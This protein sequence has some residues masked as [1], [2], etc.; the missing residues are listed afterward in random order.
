[1]SSPSDDTLANP[2]PPPSASRRTRNAPSSPHDDATIEAFADEMPG[3]STVDGSFAESNGDGGATIVESGERPFRPTATHG[4]R[5]VFDLQADASESDSTLPTDSLLAQAGPTG[6]RGGSSSTDDATIVEMPEPRDGQVIDS[7][8]QVDRTVEVDVTPVGGPNDDCTVLETP[9]AGAARG[10]RATLVGGAPQSADDRTLLDPGSPIHP[11]ND[12]TMVAEEAP[13]LAGTLASDPAAPEAGVAPPA[14]LA[15]ASAADQNYDLIEDFARGGMGKI[16]RALDRRIKREVA[17][18]ELL[19]NALRNQV[20]VERF[21]KE[22]QVTGQLEH[23]GIVPIYDMGLQKNGTP[24]YSMKLVRGSTFKKS[25]EAC[26]A[27]PKESGARRLAFIKVLQQFINICYTMGYAHERFVLHRDLKPLNIMVGDFGETLVLDWGL[28]RLMNAPDDTPLADSFV[29]EDADPSFAGTIDDAATNGQPAAAVRPGTSAAGGTT[30]GGFA[31]R[32]GATQTGTTQ[33][34]GTHSGTQGGGTRRPTV[35]TDYESAGNRT[36]MGSVMGTPAYMPPEQALGRLDELD[37]RSDIYS[38][39]AILYEILT[40]TSPIAKDKLPAMLKA[41]IESKIT[42]PLQIDATI[43]KPLAAIAMKALAKEKNDRYASAMTLAREVEAY[44]ADEPVMAYPEPLLARAGRWVRRHQKFVGSTI[45]VFV[46]SVLFGALWWRIESKRVKG[47][48]T[49]ARGRIT[50]AQTALER[51]DFT[52]A[53]RLYREAAGSVASEPTLA[54]LQEEV[55]SGIENVA[56]MQELERDAR[57]ARVRD[58]VRSELAS[59]DSARTRNDLNEALRLLTEARGKLTREPALQELL[60]EVQARIETVSAMVAQAEARDAAQSRFKEFLAE[61]DRARFYGSFFLN[62]SLE[63][64]RKE[65][66]KHGM[67]ALAMYGLDAPDATL[68]RPEYLSDTQFAA[69]RDNAFEVLLILADAEITLADRD[70]EEKRTAAADAALGWTSRARKLGVIARILPV[71]ESLAYEMKGDTENAEKAAKAAEAVVPTTALDF[72]LLGQEERFANEYD[73]AISLYQQA[74][75]VD[76]QYFWAL[77]NLGLCHLQSKRPEAALASYTAAVAARPDEPICYLT[78]AIA[79]ADLTQFDAALADLKRASDLNAPE[80]DLRLNRGGVLFG[81]RRYVEAIA[82]FEAA[83]ALRPDQSAPHRNLA[84]VYRLQ[85]DDAA[86]TKAGSGEELFK[87]AIEELDLAIDR[88][89]Q[90]AVA[91]SMRGD[92]S[93]RL[94]NAE[95]AIADFRKAAAREPNLARR[96]HSYHEIGLIHQRAGRLDEAA[97][98][99]LRALSFDDKEA[100]TH[101]LLAEVYNKL[102]QAEKAEASWTRYLELGDP[103]GDV[104]RG[105]ALSRASRGQYREAMNDY[106]RSLELEPS[107]N[108]LTR[109]GWAYLLQANRLALEDFSEAVRLNPENPDSYNGR[110]YARVMMG[111]HAAAVADAE[112]AI[113][114]AKAMADQGK[115]DWQNFYNAATIFA[116]AVDRAEKD[117]RLSEEDRERIV[118]GYTTRS[119]VTLGTAVNAAGQKNRGVLPK[120]IQSDNALDPIRQ[121]PEF[122]KIFAPKSSGASKPP[123]EKK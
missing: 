88:A 24:Y 98:E 110:G 58:E 92:V 116:Q 19:P 7:A 42:P 14:S 118:S 35:S 63:E 90:D 56:R 108:M 84:L 33:G 103:K 83:A 66:R 104:Y 78:R 105:R 123:A 15:N 43:P 115:G 79:Y 26:H 106:T 41:V 16:W 25:I 53:D 117:S 32:A 29:D 72:Y 70:D 11:G 86:R 121:R 96:A 6:R 47:I 2:E 13:E 94:G 20:V 113:K 80:Y 111:D 55:Q 69:I 34:S 62:G 61:A 1:M 22:A 39:G 95:E 38:L 60:K 36:L 37:A 30:Q 100:D 107:P 82:D 119:L 91:H 102:G 27:L 46:A 40:N 28:A 12:Q 112:E 81:A 85:G 44:L 59:A 89:P 5:T 54:G 17:F 120:T 73:E 75:Q 23:P 74:L 68:K 65:A 114:R 31:T 10:G 76:P 8:S 49:E 99:Y 50:A 67:A 48:E 87:K 64:Q 45:A 52:E 9:G 101:R 21:L 77:E 122:L 18:K 51:N 57:L 109:R 71:R 93:M 4:D 3:D 97:K